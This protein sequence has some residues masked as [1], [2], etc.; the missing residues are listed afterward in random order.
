MF[1]MSKCVCQCGIRV[2]INAKRHIA[3]SS[4]LQSST[5][6]F[7]INKLDGDLQGMGL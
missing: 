4:N 6:E 7:V 1:Q 3:L 2:A 5:D